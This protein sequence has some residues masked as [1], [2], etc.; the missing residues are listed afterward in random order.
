M[1]THQMLIDCKLLQAINVIQN[2]CGPLVRAR[3]LFYKRKKPSGLR[4]VLC[5]IKCSRVHWR[6]RV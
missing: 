1:E 2:S 4:D 6:D 5:L 3:L